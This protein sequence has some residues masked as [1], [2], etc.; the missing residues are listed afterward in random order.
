MATSLNFTQVEF[1]EL[2]DVIESFEKNIKEYSGR[3]ARQIVAMLI[4]E[5]GKEKL[6]SVNPNPTMETTDVT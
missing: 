1:P 2:F 3:S 6:Q 4:I 5:A